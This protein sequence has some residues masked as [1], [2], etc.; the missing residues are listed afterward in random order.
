MS[1]KELVE[2]YNTGIERYANAE[3]LRAIRMSNNRLTKNDADGKAFRAL[4]SNI[5]KN[6]RKYR[7]KVNPNYGT[8]EHHNHF[9]VGFCEYLLSE[10]IE[11]TMAV[12]IAENKT[13]ITVEILSIAIKTDKDLSKFFTS[14]SL[15]KSKSRVNGQK[16]IEQMEADLRKELSELEKK[17]KNKQA[18]NK[19][20]DKAWD[21]ELDKFEAEWNAIYNSSCWAV[22]A[23]M[24]ANGKDYVD[25]LNKLRMLPLSEGC[26]R[27][28]KK[29]LDD[30]ESQ[31]SEDEEIWLNN[32][33]NINLQCCP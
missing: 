3:G 31:K 30:T 14:K 23:L 24:D 20:K 1:I 28:L 9:I 19:L 8:T 6:I 22:Q 18:K 5:L 29:D 27:A 21:K 15:K 2:K 10:L 12:A 32:M 33:R 11:L 26:D 7:E 4:Y 13:N 25:T 17:Y 16:T